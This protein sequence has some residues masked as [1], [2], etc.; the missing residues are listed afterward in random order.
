[1]QNGNKRE[2]R[3]CI[4]KIK[5]ICYDKFVGASTA[6]KTG[7]GASTARPSSK[8]CPSEKGDIALAVSPKKQRR[9]QK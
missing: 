1:L 2:M 7:V 9:E 5:M 6:T 3:K 4:A 8:K